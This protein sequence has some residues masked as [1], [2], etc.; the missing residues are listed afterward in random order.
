MNPHATVLA[1]ATVDDVGIF[2]STGV[3]ALWRDLDDDAPG[4]GRTMKAVFDKADATFRRID[5]PARA[6]VLACAAAG[7]ERA[8]DQDQRNRTAI[9][10]ETGIGSLK[11]DLDFA[12]SL[13]DECVHAGIFPYSLT[14]TSLGEV[15]L[16]YKLRGP[17]ISMSTDA[18]S[19]G[20]SLREGLRMLG[21]GDVEHVLVGAVDCLAEPAH[22]IA[23]GTRAVVVLLA[24]PR[25]GVDGLATANWPP[26][27]PTC[28]KDPWRAFVTMAR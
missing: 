17:T 20:E 11:T 22:G 15:A 28:G 4:T 3:R 7:I 26:E 2:G 13:G 10:I 8:L 19:H 12:A 27:D 14:S 21:S 18:A 16:R 9:C 24:R 5:L 6:L 25:P 23:A 1:C